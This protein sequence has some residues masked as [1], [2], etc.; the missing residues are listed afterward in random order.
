MDEDRKGMAYHR[1]NVCGR[2]Y[3]CAFAIATESKT[4][5]FP[6]GSGGV[7]ALRLRHSERSRSITEQDSVRPDLA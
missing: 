4:L 2:C 6:M 3:D 5:A 1:W 7:C